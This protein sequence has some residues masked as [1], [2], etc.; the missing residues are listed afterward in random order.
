VQGQI[1]VVRQALDDQPLSPDDI[2]RVLCF[3]RAE[4]PWSRPTPGGIALLNPRGLAR[5]LRRPGPLSPGQVHH[6]A[7]VLAQRLPIA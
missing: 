5:T 7:T 1:A 6:L 2:R 4:L 3:S